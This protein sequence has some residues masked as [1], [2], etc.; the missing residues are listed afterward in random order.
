MHACVVC[1]TEYMVA[2]ITTANTT[3]SHGL[4][5]YIPMMSVW[6]KVDRAMFEE[7]LITLHNIS[8]IQNPAKLPALVPPVCEDRSI[9]V[10]KDAID[11][12]TEHQLAEDF[13]FLTSLTTWAHDVAA[14][15]VHHE[16]EPDRLCV[17]IAVN[18][19]VGLEAKRFL[20]TLIGVL[21]Q[22][23]NG[24]TSMWS[25]KDRRSY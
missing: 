7:D 6:D 3:R 16:H 23:A 4:L 25:R 22:R 13:A 19:G 18:E 8:P 5:K 11:D 14:A 9:W 20:E 15:T 2:P 17:T 12:I 10:Q 1:A 24:R 21:K